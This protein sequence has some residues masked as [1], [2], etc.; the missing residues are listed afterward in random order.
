MADHERPREST[1]RIARSRP[2]LSGWG[3]PRSLD[4]LSLFRDFAVP[5][6]VAATIWAYVDIAPRGRIDPA[7]LGR[8]KTDFTV[9]TEAGS[10]FFDGRNPYNVTN[11]RGWFY[12][13]PP[14][15]AI[16][17]SPLAAFAA[18][19]QVA[20]WFFIS[21]G[22]AFGCFLEARAILR[23]IRETD[24]STDS[25]RRFLPCCLAAAALATALL[26]TLDCLQRGQLGIMLLYFLLLGARLTW[27][28]RSAWGSFLGGLILAFPA[29]LKVVP[30]L[31]AA[32]LIGQEWSAVVFGREGRRPS[33]KAI[34]LS[35]GF[36]IGAG[37]YLFAIPASLI[38]GQRNLDALRTWADRVATNQSVGRAFHFE[39]H[40]PRNQSL[41]NAT[42]LLLAPDE[43]IAHSSFTAASTP[44]AHAWRI[45]VE[46]SA[47][48]I[49][50]VLRGL[51]LIALTIL[52]IQTGRSG[53]LERA[54]GF[55]LACAA[56][57]L[58]SPLAWGHYYMNLAPAVFFVA[59]LLV[60]RG[61]DRAAWLA[62]IVPLLLVW[63]HY[64]FLDQVGAWGALGLGTTVWF[65][66]ATAAALSPRKSLSKSL[67]PR[68][69]LCFRRLG[70]AELHLKN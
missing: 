13:Y 33:R 36:A 5:L 1:E 37:L 52:T 15:F 27:K 25:N 21:F 70:R 16:L 67:E 11:P 31:P 42:Y 29:A 60:R 44:E 35:A 30:L 12:L 64:L 54:A 56:T 66:V 20:A 43:L 51:I 69:S 40:A 9:Y 68:R 45:R 63:S 62:T 3:F 22:F 53:L 41:A 34:A 55:G 6:L 59:L 28:A 39:F 50:L 18:E 24:P 38:G 32:F 47:R 2:I 48:R 57:L 19:A 10:A 49:D 7:H 58:I 23:S 46:A 14:L 26:P 65:A 4:D 8:H 17:V 61:R